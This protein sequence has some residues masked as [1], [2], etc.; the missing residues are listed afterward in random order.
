M[1]YEESKYWSGGK[2]KASFYA[3]DLRLVKEEQ[4]RDAAYSKKV[5]PEDACWEDTPHGRLK[6]LAHE[7]INPRI[8]D[9][10][11]Y[12]QEIPA[13]SRSGKHRHMAEELM[14]ILEGRGYSLH[15]DVQ[16]DLKAEYEWKIPEEP[17]RFEWE[18][19][20]MVY[21]PVNTV[22]QHFNSDPEKPAR[23]I[24]ASNRMYKYLGFGDIEQIEPAVPASL[25]KNGR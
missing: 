18:E 25:Q 19:G 11:M 14:F 10:D 7:G 3:D 13:G 6:H 23:F 8:K 4:E 16:F 1:P 22:H 17:K 5:T 15:W 21:V 20:D 12:I 9:I 2:R 24:S